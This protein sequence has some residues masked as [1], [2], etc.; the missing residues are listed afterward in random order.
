M[1]S[2]QFSAARPGHA[3]DLAA[4]CDIA[5]HGRNGAVWQ[6]ALEKNGGAVSV[7]EIGRRAMLLRNHD[8]SLENALIAHQDG[9][10]LGA[11]FG[12]SRPKDFAGS[13]HPERFTPEMT[14]ELELK[15]M[16]G[17]SWYLAVI[18]VYREFQGRG[19]GSALL[20]QAAKRARSG[21]DRKMT[22]IVARSNAP[23]VRFYE[24]SGFRPVEE[25]PCPP[26]ADGQNADTWLLMRRMLVA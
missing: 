18:A 25:R 19:I 7:F 11:V 23:A 22:L 24:K 3:T 4:L 5:S 1:P 20:K 2:V 14:G 10:V 8:L 21:K 26:V 6:R 16:T 13:I 17:G 9:A 15:A 12:M